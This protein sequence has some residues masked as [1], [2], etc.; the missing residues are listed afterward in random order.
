MSLTE[1][2]KTAEVFVDAEGNEKVALD[3][4]VWEEIVALL[5]Q[6]DE[7]LQAELATWEALSDEALTNF[8]SELEPN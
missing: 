3:R 1:L 2:V 6:M 8:E 7:G 5:E 4:S